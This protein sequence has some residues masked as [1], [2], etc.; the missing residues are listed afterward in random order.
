[1]KTGPE[2]KSLRCAIYT[3]KSS[4]EGLDQAFNS[5]HAQREACEA[6]I[7]SQAHEGWRLIST[8]YDD[9]GFS[10]GSLER[11]ALRQLMADVDAGRIDIVVV[12]K[13]DRLTRSLADF[14]KLVERFDKTGASFVSITQ[15]FNTTT[16]MGR[17]TLNVLLSFAQFEREVT[18][19]RIRDKIAASKAKGMWMGGNL[20]LGYDAPTDPTTRALV[21]N[22]AEA[23]Q[24][25]LIFDRYLMFGCGSA[26]AAW[27]DE[28]G[29]CS[30]ARVSK[31]GRTVGGA[32]F[33]RGAL[34]YLLKNRTYLGE[35]T[36]KGRT[37][38]GAHRPIV[39]PAVFAATQALLASK[40]QHRSERPQRSATM[41]L[42]GLLF[43]ADGELMSPTFTYGRGG[44]LYRY[45]ASAPM[46]SGF[47]RAKGDGAI[48]RIP[49]DEI[50]PVIRGAL[51]RL[52][53]RSGSAPPTL[54][55]AEVY[56]DEL[57]L[58]LSASTLLAG[59]GEPEM[60]LERLT[61]R[62]AEGERAYFDPTPTLVRIILPVRVKFRG[63]RTWLAA[64]DGRALSRPAGV[65]R[66]LVSA[67]RAAHRLAGDRGLSERAAGAESDPRPMSTYERRLCRLAFL[68]PDIQTAIL[69]GGQPTS[70]SLQRLMQADVP[71]AWIDQRVALGFGASAIA[72]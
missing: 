59:H 55:R 7:K 54:Q 4:E 45:Y 60:E 43:D 8:P 25:R 31:R 37:F 26:L 38:A 33:S 30:K 49:A 50:E 35:I 44:R 32:P 69:S 21:V 1:V 9:G 57:H 63:G 22:E 61:A 10:G 53:R 68:A 65:D 23:A 46:Q 51:D 14:A 18:G 56:D 2:A 40:A 70:L 16:S 15:A 47:R 62:L 20:P 13:V 42:K 3:R 52:R 48:R 39:D 71:V 34:F 11:P 67:L 58:I 29:I 5:L 66:A 28:S 72:G 27:L 17:L 36:H 64:P 12:Y 41:A 19:E 6:Y 24:V